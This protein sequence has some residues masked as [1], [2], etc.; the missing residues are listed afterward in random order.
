GER[1]V[2]DGKTQ[3]VPKYTGEV[4]VFDVGSGEEKPPLRHD[5]QGAVAAIQLGPDGKTL[6]ARE[7]TAAV[8]DKGDRTITSRVIEWDLGKR[9][10]RVVAEGYR[11]AERSPNGR[12]SA[13][14][15]TDYEKLT[16]SLKLTDAKSG[17]EATLLS[18]DKKLV[19]FVLL[20]PDS[21]FLAASVNSFGEGGSEL[22][23]WELPAMKEVKVPELKGGVLD[24]ACAPDGSYLAVWETGSGT[25]LIDTKT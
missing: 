3:F 25:R 12:W 19:G 23:V 6:I 18:A 20:A 9:A 24:L 22:R 17:K 5:G 13:A 11:E 4:R 21:R 7:T 8:N 16:T 2:K 14:S 1:V 15:F 10:H